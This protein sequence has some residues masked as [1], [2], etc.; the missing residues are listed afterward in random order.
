MDDRP[1]TTKFESV[2]LSP[3]AA[4]EYDQE[5]NSDGSSQ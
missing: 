1:A 4:P 2:L 3:S 5:H